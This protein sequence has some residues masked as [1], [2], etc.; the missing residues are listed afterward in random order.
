[1]RNYGLVSNPIESK[2]IRVFK[3]YF[4]FIKIIY[5]NLHLSHYEKKS[6]PLAIGFITIDL[7]RPASTVRTPIIK[8][9]DSFPNATLTNQKNDEI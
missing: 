6:T 9:S 1:L 5:N 7:R 2:I 8:R 3:N 4:S